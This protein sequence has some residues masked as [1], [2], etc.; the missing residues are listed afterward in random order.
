MTA[1]SVST[2]SAQ[3]VSRSPE[4]IQRRRGTF[5]VSPSK[6]TRTN[7]IQDRT[8]EIMSSDVVMTSDGRGPRRRP[9]SP[10]MSAPASGRRTIKA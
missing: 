4:V 2:R 9:N 7:T 6:P 10:A 1:V 8:A 3:A 5:A